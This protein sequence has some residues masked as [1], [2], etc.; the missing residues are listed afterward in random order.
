M[1]RPIS[2]LLGVP[3][4]G[5]LWWGL[6]GWAL[7]PGDGFAQALPLH[8]LVARMWRAG[9]VPVWNSYT[10]SGSPLLANG[11]AG[12]LYPPNLAFV[13]L[14][15]VVA[16]NLTMLVSFLV[17]GTG[18]Y[19]LARRTSGDAWAALV[20]GVAFAGSGFMFGH[21]VH[22]AILASIGWL[23]W[24]LYGFDLCLERLT[25]LHLAVGGGAVALSE[26]AGQG[27]TFS[28]VVL[29]V[30][31][32]G[33]VMAGPDVRAF[34]RRSAR[35]LAI[36]A[37]MI[38]VGSGLAAIQLLPTL[39]I[40]GADSYRLSY[41]VARSYSFSLSHLPLVVFPYLF[42]STSHVF[43]Y[44][45]VYQ[46]LWNVDELSG[47]VGTAALGFAAAGVTAVRT[48][49]RAAALVCLGA[50]GLLLASAGGS[51]LGRALYCVPVYGNFRDWGRYVV[52][53]D[54]AVAVL[55]AHGAAALRSSDRA[56]RSRAARRAWSVPALVVIVAAAV[57]L[58]G[59]V[60]RF[61][62]RGLT[63]WA[64]IAVPLTGALAGA[65]AC[66][67][68]ARHL[69]WA[70]AVAVGIVASDLVLAFGGW[71]LDAVSARRV[72]AVLART[73][74][75]SWGPRPRRSG[76]GRFLFAG[77][78]TLASTSSYPDLSDVEGLRSANGYVPLGLVPRDYATVV[79]QMD[80]EGNVASPSVLWQRGS[81]VLD[82][83]RVTTVLID[84]AATSSVPDATGTVPSA[85]APV[86][87]TTLTRYE[88]IPALADAMIVGAVRAAPRDQ[89]IKAVDGSVP[90]D[91]VSEALI[92]SACQSCPSGAPGGAG[93]VD[94]EIWGD[95]SIALDVAAERP[96]MLVVSE[97]WFP[98]WT[99]SV[100]GRA[101]EAR[102]AD[103]LVIGVVIPAGAHRVTL[104]YRAPGL[105]WGA[106]A[107]GAT[108]VLLV[109]WGA[110]AAS[111]RRGARRGDLAPP[112]PRCR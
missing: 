79:G 64:A 19:V 22:Q 31:A 93:T 108:V 11:I 45:A 42:G 52:L 20:A 30:A 46:G 80:Y 104:Q 7:V 58:M 35:S 12:A 8:V 83:L 44:G 51:P 94:H 57:H 26:L 112:T 25:A 97:A 82:L 81:H 72:D 49:R 95:G 27:Q 109:A 38:L 21:I 91:P 41:D 61:E 37:T 73:A 71:R 48:D 17:A 59:P 96:G 43:P 62:V 90:F 88:R 3:A 50:V 102:R 65:L 55:A 2:L 69:R 66:A 32:Y 67:A 36:G 15:P 16:N 53:C 33:L 103:G 54:L 13:V 1:A 18:A 78:H 70:R 101:V 100:D 47:Y 85:G 76:I 84:P 74:T 40:L 6:T 87:G 111:G 56:A 107:S 92:E 4:A 9:T 75:P 98:G 60:R 106:G 89:V 14:P 5:L 29:A 110:V 39:A 23:P 99:A 34:P 105:A 10:Y 77:E 63:A 28:T 68:V 86:A 24:A